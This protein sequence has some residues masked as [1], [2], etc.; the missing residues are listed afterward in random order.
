MKEI[1]AI[2]RQP[3]VLVQLE[4]L[5]DQIQTNHVL[6]EDLYSRLEKVLRHGDSQ[7]IENC[8]TGENSEPLVSL[9]NEIL[10]QR[11]KV[12]QSNDQLRN[13]MMTLEL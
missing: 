3:Q 2:K 6:I 9:A 10:T 11:I 13:I 7:L 1:N 5:N 8:D 12:E 4:K